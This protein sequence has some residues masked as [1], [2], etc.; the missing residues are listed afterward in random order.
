M[1][2]LQSMLESVFFQVILAITGIG[3]FIWGIFSHYASNKKPC[4]STARSSFVVV[5]RGRNSIDNLTLSFAGKEIQN[6]T[7]TKFAIWNSGNKVIN[8]DDLVST[9]K[10]QIVAIDSTEIL[11]AQI[12]AETDTSNRFEIDSQSDNRVCLD[13]EYAD[14]HD[15]IVLQVLHTGNRDGLKVEGKIKGGESIKCF[16]MDKRKGR[17]Q[18]GQAYTR[19]VAAVFA[20]IYAAILLVIVSVFTLVSLGAIPDEIAIVIKGI[21]DN[22]PMLLMAM[23]GTVLIIIAAVAK[24]IKN[25]F[26]VGVPGKLKTY[27]TIVEK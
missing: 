10:L 12:V 2:L 6:L 18:R 7:I 9:Q 3:G 15:G 19:K 17:K 8:A 20:A 14:S 16:G 11:E 5:S 1:E 4:I 26:L 23:W 21:P 13:F 22:L 24:I 27:S 25:T